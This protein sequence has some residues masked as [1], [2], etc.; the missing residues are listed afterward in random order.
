MDLKDRFFGNGVT[1]P[2][3]PPV[4]NLRLQ[5]PPALALLF[6]AV[7]ELDA[8]K[9]TLALR[10]YH[11]ELASATAEILS[12]PPGPGGEPDAS[13]A[14]M[15]L[16]GW[17]KH[18]VKVVGFGSPMPASAVERCVEPA[19]YDMAMKQ[20]AMK[21]AAHVLLFYAGYETDPLEQYVALAAAG[22][23]LTHLGALVVLNEAG[24][25]S[26]PAVVLLPHEEDNGDTLAAL[27]G[28]PL[29]F[30]YAGFVRMQVDGEPGVWMRTRGAH[31]FKLPDLA[32][33][34]DSHEQTEATFHLFA[35]LLAH[36]REQ[37]QPFIPG[38]T[39]NIGGGVVLSLREPTEA[40]WFLENEG[41]LL[42]AEPATPEEATP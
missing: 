16:L 13:L 3:G 42:V 18:V 34:A 4:V 38:D 36:Q 40:E 41:P 8:E 9:L 14:V 31:A 15:G 20:E 27:R 23:A 29:I 33:R 10:D 25:T 17:G 24:H 39:L 5:H 1:T 35:N 26:V 19:H 11:P 32:L 37:R 28:L 21:H 2:G 12:V 6:P 7:P 30:L 22:A